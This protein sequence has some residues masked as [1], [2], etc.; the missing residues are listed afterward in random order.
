MY[1]IFVGKTLFLYFT[2]LIAENTIDERILERAEIKKRLDSVVI[3]QGRLVD[4][5]K[6][7]GQ[8]EMLNMIRHG[9]AKIFTDEMKVC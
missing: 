4:Q 8:E 3:Q 5:Q 2:R 1:Q 9:A 6:K 7:L